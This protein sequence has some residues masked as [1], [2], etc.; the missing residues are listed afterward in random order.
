MLLIFKCKTKGI[1]WET[2]KIVLRGRLYGDFQPWLK[3]QLVKPLNVSYNCNFFQLGTR[4]WTFNPGWKSPY[5][6]PFKIVRGT[7]M[8]LKRRNI[9]V[10][11]NVLVMFTIYWIFVNVKRTI[12]LEFKINCW[13]HFAYV[14]YLRKT[15]ICSSKAS[16]NLII[17]SLGNNISVVKSYLNPYVFI[18]FFH[19]SL[20]I[21]V[22][23]WEKSSSIKM[24]LPSNFLHSSKY[25]STYY[26]SGF[27]WILIVPSSNFGFRLSTLGFR[28]WISTVRLSNFEFIN[29]GHVA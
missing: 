6:Q 13:S 7:V 18:L 5:N 22:V 9:L 12:Q 29:G 27:S 26:C 16:L 1:F 25:M 8:C 15:L 20:R 23:S 4:S 11:V 10:K 21:S 14:L 24:F 2:L 19:S 17:S 3:I 28:I